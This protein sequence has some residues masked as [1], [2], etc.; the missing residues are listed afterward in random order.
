MSTAQILSAS[1]SLVGRKPGDDRYCESLSASC[2]SPPSLQ[3]SSSSAGYAAN[4]NAGTGSTERRSMLP[5]PR[6]LSGNFSA[7]SDNAEHHSTDG[8]SGH[9]A[10]NYCSTA[11]S[12]KGD[13]AGRAPT[14][15]SKNDTDDNDESSSNSTIGGTARSRPR[16]SSSTTL[17]GSGFEDMLCAAAERIC[18]S[19]SGICTGA[20]SPCGKA[21]GDSVVE[22][23][24]DE[25]DILLDNESRQEKRTQ[26]QTDDT[27]EGAA[28][29]VPT[30]C[31]SAVEND[32]P[33]NES[34]PHL[35]AYNSLLD[36]TSHSN[37]DKTTAGEQNSGL[38]EAPQQQHRGLHNLGNTCYLNSALQVLMTLEG[39]VDDVLDRTHCGELAN[40][41]GNNGGG[42][43]S[44]GES[45]GGWGSIAK[46]GIAYTHAIA[47]CSA[48]PGVAAAVRRASTTT[49]SAA[50]ASGLDGE[51]DAGSAAADMA[52]LDSEFN[53][54]IVAE[55]RKL[56]EVNSKW[57]GEEEKEEEK[58][59]DTDAD[60]SNA[61]AENRE[62]DADRPLHQALGQVFSHLRSSAVN[63]PSPG[64]SRTSTTTSSSASSLSDQDATAVNPAKLKEAVDA[65]APQFVGYE[66]QDSHELLCTLLDMLHDEVK[67]KDEEKAKAAQQQKEQE[68]A[69]AEGGRK[70]EETKKEE[71]E[72]DGQQAEDLAIAESPSSDF[73]SPCKR[74]RCSSPSLVSEDGTGSDAQDPRELKSPPRNQS[75]ADLSVADIS[76][77]LHD[78]RAADNV[79]NE[80]SGKPAA[81]YEDI[82]R[83]AEQ[84]IGSCEIRETQAKPTSPV[85]A[86]FATEIRTWLTCDSCKFSRSTTE[87]FRCLSLDV[88]AADTAGSVTTTTIEE[89][90]RRFFASEKRDIKC[91][92]CFFETATQTSEI[93][94]LPRALLLHFKRFIVDVAPDYSSVSYRKDTRQVSFSEEIALGEV[95]N[96]SLAD[97]VAS[98]CAFPPVRTKPRAANSRRSSTSSDG[99]SHEPDDMS[100][101]ES[102]AYRLRGIVHHIGQ[103]ANRG[104]YTAVTYTGPPKHPSSASVDENGNSTTG[105]EEKVWTKFNDCHVTKI[106]ADEALG[107]TAQKT[108]YIVLYALS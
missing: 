6:T 91:E 64:R 20:G 82:S 46:D 102:R 28:A 7:G 84:D 101:E 8:G 1:P 55:A 61:N 10:N 58:E 72:D 37:T 80:N 25:D 94:K 43:G 104:H 23:E 60:E 12:R 57:E 62:R 49:C 65:H 52:R 27:S 90:L 77:L 53:R 81:S 19:G 36:A 21:S 24:M 74:P 41:C 17:L 29:L 40:G 54:G 32:T 107:E 30:T 86:H 14:G 39:F 108:A 76:S 34:F 3:L 89:A 16:S 42:S 73:K 59:E 95:G 66:Q 70:D 22:A 11:R 13:V 35:T 38:V 105:G 87:K 44:G 31:T 69:A 4:A 98:D 5:R 100:V 79:D 106:S 50:G 26:P 48:G 68:H 33:M 2:S 99:I 97:Y 9:A 103:S 67:A 18:T 45:G 75:L 92:K 56:G 88:A 51:G 47:C 93:T 85:E 78:K 63:T 71:V 15:S 96:A 83:E